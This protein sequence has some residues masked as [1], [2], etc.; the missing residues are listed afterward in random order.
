MSEDEMRAGIRDALQSLNTDAERAIRRELASSFDL[1]HSKRLQFEVCPCFF[2]IHLVQ[3]EETIL[4]D[5]VILDAMSPQFCYAAEAAG[6]DP[7]AALSEE[8]FPWFAERW[9]AAGGPARFCPAYAFFHG[10]LDEPRYD[11]ERRRWCAV[12]EVWPEEA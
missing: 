1:G 7:Y 11:L 12:A 3:T 4:A 5:S 8:L 2:G 9:Q 6:L 10:G